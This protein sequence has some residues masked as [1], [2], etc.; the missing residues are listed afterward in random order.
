M[1]ADNAARKPRG[2]S[3]KGTLATRRS[4]AWN[5]LSPASLPAPRG[6]GPP[7]SGCADA[8]CPVRSSE[9]GGSSRVQEPR[10]AAPAAETCPRLGSLSAVAVPR[11]DGSVRSGL[12]FP[13]P[14]WPG[15]RLAPHASLPAETRAPAAAGRR[16]QA[17]ATL[18]RL[19]GAD[20][21][22]H[23]CP[24]ERAAL[25]GEKPQGAVAWKVQ[26]LSG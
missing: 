11:G 13:G 26:V 20:R 2:N 3:S 23:L 16:D 7:R 15:P 19:G 6:A 4:R 24:E 14:R 12:C 1:A 5:G 18:L 21:L 10:P 22:S 17:R 25:A 8:S 9:H